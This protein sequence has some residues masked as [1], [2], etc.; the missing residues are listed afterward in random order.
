[1]VKMVGCRVFEGWWVISR[2]GT[3]KHLI[4]AKIQYLMAKT[5]I[6]SVPFKMRSLLNIQ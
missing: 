1:M 5:N 4:V 6:K 2:Y 3:M